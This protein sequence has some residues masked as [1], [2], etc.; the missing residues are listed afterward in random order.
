MVGGSAS[1]VC[2]FTLPAA[3]LP[4]EGRFF[5]SEGPW[6][7]P[8]SG[9]QLGQGACFDFGN[10]GVFVP[11]NQVTTRFNRSRA[12]HIICFAVRGLGTLDREVVE[13]ARIEARRSLL[14]LLGGRGMPS[15]CAAAWSE[16]GFR[17][18]FP[19][20][21][22]TFARFERSSVLAPGGSVYRWGAG[23]FEPQEGEA[24]IAQPSGPWASP[25]PSLHESHPDWP[26]EKQSRSQVIR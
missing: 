14:Q 21:V 4:L 5:R 8:A 9:L 26:T 13:Q 20:N 7:S 22:E 24:Q 17:P 18:R 15:C 25:S 12:V 1:N 11:R 16:G 23:S 19:G 3:D 2:N 10:S 6:R